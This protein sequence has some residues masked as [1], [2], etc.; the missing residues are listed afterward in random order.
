MLGKA[1]TLRRAAFVRGTGVITVAAIRSPCAGAA[2]AGSDKT[3]SGQPD[4]MALVGKSRGVIGRVAISGTEASMSADVFKGVMPAL[5]TP[6]TRDRQ[7]D[8]AA[9]VRKGRELMATGMSAVIYCG[10]MGEWPLLND[11]Q[12][13]EVVVKMVL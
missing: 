13:M 9:L 11:E 1:T 4:T 2:G 10:S 12:R 8:F 3:A 6:W 5:M 7:P